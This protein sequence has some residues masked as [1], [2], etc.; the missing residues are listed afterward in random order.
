MPS[1]FK[2]D[3]PVRKRRWDANDWDTA[4]REGRS[5]R[6]DSAPE[7]TRAPEDYFT[8]CEANGLVVSPYGVLAFALCG[9]EE[10]LCRVDDVLV[11]GKSSVLAPGD[12]VFI[13]HDERGPVVRAVRP[14][15]N[16]LSRPA[17]ARDREQVFAANVDC[18]VIVASV[19]RPVF[20]PGLIDRYLVAAQAGG[21][22]PV[23][24][25]NKIDLANGE[26]DG[27][28]VYRELGLRVL[29]T[30]CETAEG[31]EPLR[32]LLRDKCSVLV[33]HS[34]V[35]KSSL[36]NALD[37][38]LTIYT[39][40]I[41]DSTNKGRHTTSASRLYELAGNIRI[42]DTPGVKMLGLWGVTPA[43]LNY[44]FHEL[45]E[46]SAGCKFRDCTHTHEPKCGV[47]DAVE[48]G[49]IAKARYDSYL[50][51]RASFSESQH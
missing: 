12:R 33:G 16:K 32:E 17:I 49:S 24:C 25:V 14:R 30:S 15:T 43:E 28:A 13:E 23:I 5:K 10:C 44:Y 21:V 45:A 7:Q 22:E 35:G 29:G 37:P 48:A 1:P 27:V 3:K 41:S 50:R 42:I 46:A 6:A 8:D 38:D 34:G 20:N 40:E 11:D 39:Q 36:V 47:R 26:P 19:V 31:L 9:N 18:A 4:S 51:I 2:R